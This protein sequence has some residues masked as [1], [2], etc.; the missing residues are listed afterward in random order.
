MRTNVHIKIPFH[1]PCAVHQCTARDMGLVWVL[2]I[3][4]G[5]RVREEPREEGGDVGSGD[6]CVEGHGV[7][8]GEIKSQEAITGRCQS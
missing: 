6:I 2:A 3:G 1:K 5:V 4:I 7:C 8:A